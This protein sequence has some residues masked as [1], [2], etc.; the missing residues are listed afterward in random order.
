MYVNCLFVR[1]I[2]DK[3]FMYH[4]NH[5]DFNSLGILNIYTRAESVVLDSIK[6]YGIL[7]QCFCQIHVLLRASYLWKVDSLWDCK[8]SYRDS[9]QLSSSQL[10]QQGPTNMTKEMSRVPSPGAVAFQLGGDTL[11]MFNCNQGHAFY[12]ET[13]YISN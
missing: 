6:W 11:N 8:C 3:D 10:L 2:L 12:F 9:F 4:I 1:F 5:T 7:H 13:S